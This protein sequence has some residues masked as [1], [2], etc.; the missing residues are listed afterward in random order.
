MEY[1]LQPSPTRTGD[2]LHSDIPGYGRGQWTPSVGGTATYTNQVGRYVLLGDVVFIS[3]RL[4][5]NTIGS[6][7]AGN[8][9]NLP[10]T[11]SGADRRYAIPVAYIETAAISFIHIVMS[12][13]SGSN[14]LAIRGLTASGASF[15][16]LAVLGNGTWID[17]SGFYDIQK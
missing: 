2:K 5:I 8:I 10:F 14:T 13:A 15:V 3:A 7:L 4:Q 9:L 12:I 17:F 11:A 1:P 6:G 16:D